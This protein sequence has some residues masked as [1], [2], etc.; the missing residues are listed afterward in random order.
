MIDLLTISC[1]GCIRMNQQIAF[2]GWLLVVLLFFLPPSSAIAGVSEDQDA[3]ADL[4]MCYSNVYTKALYSTFV[5]QRDFDDLDRADAKLRAHVQSRYSPQDREKL[6]L[7]GSLA[8]HHTQ[9]NKTSSP[10]EIVRTCRQLVQM[11]N[12]NY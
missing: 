4:Q 2:S 12:Q 9:P 3:Y 6:V 10:D 1:D 5:L 11:I 8:G 7:N